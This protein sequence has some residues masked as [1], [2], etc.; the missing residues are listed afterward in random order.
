L[1]KAIWCETEKQKTLSE[2]KLCD[3]LLVGNALV[4][5]IAKQI[6]SIICVLVKTADKLFDE[7]LMV[8]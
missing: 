2:T 5:G 6:G 8:L 1:C 3:L 4:A 7:L